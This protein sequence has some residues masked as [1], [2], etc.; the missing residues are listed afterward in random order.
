MSRFGGILLE[1]LG[2][3]VIEYIQDKINN[4]TH[5]SGQVQDVVTKN[6]MQEIMK[7]INEAD[8]RLQES[9]N[10]H[11]HDNRYRKLTD[12]YSKEEVNSKI[13]EHITTNNT[14]IMSSI[15]GILFNDSSTVKNMDN[16]S[17]ENS[18]NIEAV[19]SVIKTTGESPFSITF[20][21]N[22]EMLF[23]GKNMYKLRINTN[24]GNGKISLKI[25]SVKS[26]EPEIEDRIIGSVYNKTLTISNQNVFIDI[27]DVF[28][29]KI[30]DNSS[31]GIEI[32]VEHSNKSES[33]DLELDHIF[34]T[35]AMPGMF[36]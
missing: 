13:V 23:L 4:H 3:S 27:Y 18:S 14:I 5:D 26:F 19:G 11:N 12:S 25:N 7:S 2:D 36:I 30:L 17:I 15:K 6:E 29:M 35:P 34:I 10:T 24:A 32:V 9:I 31:I 22:R 21:V 33:Y 1:Q 28:D 8:N 16:C 20:Q